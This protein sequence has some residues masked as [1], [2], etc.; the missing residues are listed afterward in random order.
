M[1]LSTQSDSTDPWACPATALGAYVLEVWR[2]EVDG[3][4]EPMRCSH[5]PGQTRCGV[6]GAGLEPGEKR[7]YA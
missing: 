1:P 4:A 7:W 3:E 5:W 2:S 6:C